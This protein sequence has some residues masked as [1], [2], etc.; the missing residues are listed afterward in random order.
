MQDETDLAILIDTGITLY[1]QYIS[2]DVK[3]FLDRAIETTEKALVQ[4]I[5]HPLRANCLNNLSFF[6]RIRSELSLS[7]ESFSDLNRA[8]HL[9]EEGLAIESPHRATLQHTYSNSLLRRYERSNVENDLDT[10]IRASEIA[11]AD[12][13]DVACRSES[14]NTLGVLLAEKYQ[15]AGMLE[16]I[17]RAI[18][19]S[20][21]ALECPG[22]DDVNRAAF[23]N[24]LG[25]SLQLRMEGI[26]STDDGA[27]AIE[28][29]KKAVKLVNALEYSNNLGDAY[30][31]LFEETSEIMHLYD[32]IKI[33]ERVVEE[34]PKNHPAYLRRLNNL[35]NVLQRRFEW[36]KRC[37][38]VNI[39]DL[40]RVV[41]LRHRAIRNTPNDHPALVVLLQNYGSLLRIQAKET[42][43]EKGYEDAIQ[44][45]QSAI[46]LSPQDHPIRAQLFQT[47]G[48]IYSN[49]FERGLQ[50][51]GS[52]ASGLSLLWKSVAAY[53]VAVGFENAPYS[54]RITA[55]YAAGCRLYSVDL[56]RASSFLTKAVRWLPYCSPRSLTREDQQNVLTKFAG[57]VN[58]ATSFIL[59]SSKPS[60][61]SPETAG[62]RSGPDIDEA[63]EIF[64]LGR[65][66][67][68]SLYLATKSDINDLETSEYNDLAAEFK[69][70]RNLVD[71]FPANQNKEISASQEAI[72]VEGRNRHELVADFNSL[73]D[74][75]RSRPGFSRFLLGP[76]SDEIKGLAEPGP[77]VLFNV[78][79]VRSDAIIITSDNIRCLPL[80]LPPSVVKLRAMSFTDALKADN[81]ERRQKT[82]NE[83]RTT[84][85]WLWDS[86][87]F[88]VLKALNLAKPRAPEEPWTQIWWVP[89][90]LL[91]MFP[92]HAAGRGRKDFAANALE[93]VISSYTPTIR[94]LHYARRTPRKPP[95]T[96]AKQIL[97]V[98]MPK[99]PNRNDL[100]FVE[101]EIAAIKELFPVSIS[102]F[103]TAPPT[104]RK[105]LNGLEDC[106]AA[107]FA[108]HGESMSS[109]PSASRLLLSDHETDSLT[110]ADLTAL[111]VENKQLIY[112][113]ACESAQIAVSSLQDEG[114]HLAG[115]CLLAGFPHVVATLWT[116][117][118]RYS[119]KIA[120]DVYHGIS[121]PDKIIE[122]KKTAESLHMAVRKLRGDRYSISPLFWAAY[123]HMGG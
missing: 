72:M 105:V 39:Q 40:D 98:A 38:E 93:C 94:A 85:E 78:A 27:E 77:I 29:F 8:I 21:E 81:I 23:C 116:I 96:D 15:R 59:E 11:V 52:Q 45:I 49:Q 119:V 117:Y 34:T 97:L 10:A 90:G 101:H 31:A 65:G 84:L 111:K 12:A 6:L 16:Y 22:L 3:Q 57:L 24:T 53:E 91:N 120:E 41:K 75:I 4:S 76:T 68:A 113:S 2:T 123:V 79:S 46:K 106:I 115:A 87:V 1:N 118:D 56:K 103:S 58:N 19:A 28:M 43:S 82:N 35:A 64:E 99:T 83:I 26:G 54:L 102:K 7:S 122:G 18:D 30:R 32:A 110:V 47:L 61:D 44:V 51:G 80:D 92:I 95:N 74:K 107:H 73:I 20:K 67:M 70:L 69:R 55:A 114:L 104:K 86:A 121:D 66:V 42:G 112:L 109:N 89:G 62:L 37:G 60:S 14:L 5:G 108:T 13:I 71:S 100:P 88:P 33:C 25:N 17:N 63:L 50:S 48:N 9:I 36:Q